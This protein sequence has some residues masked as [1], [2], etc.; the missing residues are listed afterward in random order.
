MRRIDPLHQGHPFHPLGYEQRTDCEKEVRGGDC[1]M[2]SAM[3][4]IAERTRTRVSVKEVIQPQVPL[5]LPCYDFAPVTALAFGGLVLSVPAPTSGTHSFHG[6]TG[7]VYKA[8]ERI[9]RG[10]ADPRLLAIPA[11]CS[12]VADCN[13]N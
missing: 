6:V 13:P 2:L 11:S 8:R 4:V 7:G 10:V 3:R 12:R 1:G 5:R 9:H